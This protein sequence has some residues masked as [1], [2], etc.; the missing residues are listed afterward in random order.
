MKHDP[1]VSELEEML[2]DIGLGEVPSLEA[3]INH[4][5]WVLDIN[6]RLNLTRITD[7]SG[8]LRLHILDSLVALPELEASPAGPLLDLGSGAGFPGVPLGLATGRETTLVDSVAKKMHALQGYLDAA[9]MAGRFRTSTLRAE[10]LATESPTKWAAVSARAVTHLASLVELAAPLLIQGGT[11][12]ALKGAIDNEELRRGARVSKMV[13]LKLTSQ[14]FLSLPR[15]GEARNILTFT[16]VGDP[17]VALP[18]RVGLAQKKP[19]A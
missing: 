18:R 5:D 10:S 8:A 6:E 4:L 12:I 13:G 11:L 15:G 7:P 3:M 19:L 17:D 2:G 16:R 9:G 14:R 1:R